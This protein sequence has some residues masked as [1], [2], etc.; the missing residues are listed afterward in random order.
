M[1]LLDSLT[2]PTIQSYEERAESFWEGT[3]DHDV[4]QNVDALLGALEGDGPH[5]ILDF[6]CGPGRDLADFRRRG[7]IPIGVEGSPTFCKMARDFS[8]ADVWHQNFLSLDLPD[9]HFDGVFAN[10]TLFHVPRSELDRVLG[11]LHRALKPSGV[12]FSSNPRGDNEEGW[13]GDRYS[14]YHDLDAWKRF[15]NSA[16]FVFLDHYYRPAGLPRAEQPWLATTFRKPR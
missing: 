6:G 13:N 14:S 11:Q 8:G 7:H 4:S 12:L 3:R 2:G 1:S 10:A 9:E 15:M 16:G 5:R